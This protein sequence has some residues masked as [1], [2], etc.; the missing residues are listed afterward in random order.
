MKTCGWGWHRHPQP[1]GWLQG[2]P[3]AILAND[4][5]ARGDLWEFW[6]KNPPGKPSHGTH[7]SFTRSSENHHLLKSALFFWDRGYVIGPS[8]FGY[9]LRFQNTIQNLTCFV[10]SIHWE[11]V[12]RMVLRKGRLGCIWLWNPGKVYLIYSCYIK[13][14]ANKGWQH[15]T[16]CYLPPRSSTTTLVEHVLSLETL[17]HKRGAARDVEW[18]LGVYIYKL[19][20]NRLI[21]CPCLSFEHASAWHCVPIDRIRYST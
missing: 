13:L 20:I 2:I 11:D 4:S 21:A 9:T 10:Q 17:V 5:L 14:P 19:N 1:N 16:I 3:A 15:G 18:N 7:H 6:R 8:L 12:F